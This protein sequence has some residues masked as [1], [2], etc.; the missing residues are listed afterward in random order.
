MLWNCGAVGIEM[1]NW[2]GDT[3]LIS[4]ITGRDGMKTP[5]IGGLD[6]KLISGIN[7]GGQSPVVEMDQP[8]LPASCRIPSCAEVSWYEKMSKLRI[9]SS[10]GKGKI[11]SSELTS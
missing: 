1:A 11:L 5:N 7:L 10:S 8:K 6:G 9:A 3:V 2:L 4:G